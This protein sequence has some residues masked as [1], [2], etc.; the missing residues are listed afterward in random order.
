MVGP[1]E[2]TIT[3]PNCGHRNHTSYSTDDKKRFVCTKCGASL[4]VSKST[5]P[6]AFAKKQS[7]KGSSK[8]NNFFGWVVI[9]FLIAIGIV[10]T[11]F[12]YHSK[13]INKEDFIASFADTPKVWI[14]SYPEQTLPPNG[15][16]QWFTSDIRMAPFKV[17]GKSGLH[18]LVK[19]CDFYTKKPILTVFVRNGFIINLKVPLGSYELKYA[20]GE[21]WYG[22]DHL[23]GPTTAY[24]RAEKRLDF[25]I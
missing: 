11:H 19:L 2:L 9:V 13:K 10:T 1:K 8:E 12:L 24:H 4:L 3:C 23:F 16:V 25:F 14:P 7:D 21:K 22:Y 6:D 20:A 18:Y 15:T 5:E 17:Q